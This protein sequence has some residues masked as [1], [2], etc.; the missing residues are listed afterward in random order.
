M[1]NEKLGLYAIFLTRVASDFQVLLGKFLK[2]NPQMSALF[3]VSLTALALRSI[4]DT[5]GLRELLW[6][7]RFREIQLL[8]HRRHPKD[9]YEY[10]FQ[11]LKMNF[12]HG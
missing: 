12:E 11:L 8:T 9:A 1:S 10:H 2:A 4:D 5:H 6:R 3:T 7:Q